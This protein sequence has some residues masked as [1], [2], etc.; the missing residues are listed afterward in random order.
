[1]SRLLLDTHAALWWLDDDARLSASTREAIGDASNEVY[2][3]SASLWEIAIKTSIG[4]LEVDDDLP[5]ILE[6][7]G[8]GELPVTNK[9]AW[10]SRL[11]P[12]HHRD[13]FDRLLVAQAKAEELTLVSGDPEFAAYGVPLLW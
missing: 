5:A 12:M 9:H 13:P 3:S 1:M 10:E 8:F 6:E 4:K 7:E 11:L 2:V